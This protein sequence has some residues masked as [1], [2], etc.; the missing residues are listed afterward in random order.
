VPI[1]FIFRLMK[2][3]IVVLSIAGG[4]SGVRVVIHVNEVGI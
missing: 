4:T 2:A 1:L 3:V